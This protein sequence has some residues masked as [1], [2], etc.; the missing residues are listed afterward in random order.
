MWLPE[1]NCHPGIVIG[2]YCLYCYPWLSVYI[3]RTGSF[4]DFLC[5]GHLAGIA[6]EFHSTVSTVEA[7]NAIALIVYFNAVNSSAAVL[8]LLLGPTT[9]DPL[10]VSR[11]AL[12]WPVAVGGKCRPIWLLSWVIPPYAKL[13]R[14]T[15]YLSS[16]RRM[17]RRH[18]WFYVYTCPLPRKQLLRTLLC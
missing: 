9:L 10:L 7:V 2:V 6:W 18:L 14:K 15:A 8:I 11:F 5:N 17:P 16:H 1:R 13:L 3:L 12:G 4:G